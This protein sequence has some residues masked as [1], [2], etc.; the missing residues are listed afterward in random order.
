MMLEEAGLADQIIES[1][2]L[3]SRGQDM[4]G[5]EELVERM[6]EAGWPSDHSG[7]R[8]YVDL[9]DSY[10]SVREALRHAGLEH[11]RGVEAPGYTPRI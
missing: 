7:G 8:Q 10:I 11:G 2:S 3:V 1:L 6:K 5:V 9:P 4:V